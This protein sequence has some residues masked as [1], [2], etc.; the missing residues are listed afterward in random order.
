MR[1]LHK[2]ELKSADSER[3]QISDQQRETAD[4][5]VL[6]SQDSPKTPSG[7]Y[8]VEISLFEVFLG[9]FTLWSDL[10]EIY[11]FGISL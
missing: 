2:G 9:V 8:L 4:L 6:I 1:Y 10:F 3:E 7:I 5:V 11:L